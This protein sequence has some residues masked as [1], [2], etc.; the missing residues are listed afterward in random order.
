MKV[1][2]E[3]G[4]DSDLMAGARMGRIGVELLMKATICAG[5]IAVVA[6]MVAALFGS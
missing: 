1:T 2:I 5:L 6:G 3:D 4:T